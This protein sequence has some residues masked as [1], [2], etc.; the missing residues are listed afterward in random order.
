MQEEFKHTIAKVAVPCHEA[1]IKPASEMAVGSATVHRSRLRCNYANHGHSK[2]DTEICAAI[3]A[4]NYR[5]GA[6]TNGASRCSAHWTSFINTNHNLLTTLS[7]QSLKILAMRIFKQDAG[8][9]A[10]LRAVQ[11]YTT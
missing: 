8:H 5:I 4:D 11:A 10:G 9:P 7:A 2:L 6:T 1:L 3:H